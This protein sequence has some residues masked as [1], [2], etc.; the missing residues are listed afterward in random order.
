[1]SIN[2][3]SHLSYTDFP[4][5]FICQWS[6]LV[7]QTFLSTFAKNMPPGGDAID[8]GANVGSHTWTLG[9]IVRRTNNT[10]LSVEPDENNVKILEQ[11][12]KD[13]NWFNMKIIMNP[14]SNVKKNVHF[15]YAENCQLNK[16]TNEDQPN[17]VYMESITLDEI[18]QGYCPKFIKIDVEGQEINAII[19][20]QET[21]LKHR[22]II[23]TEFGASEYSQNDINWYYHFFKSNNYLFLDL[24]GDEFSEIDFVQNHQ[25]YW[26]RFLIPVEYAHIV[27]IFKNNLKVIYSLY[28]LEDNENFKIS[29]D[30]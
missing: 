22:P 8:L 20:G 17:T 21:V 29:F 25:R 12:V 15:L 5:Y 2:Y 3:K 13:T 19:G 30:N 24:F 9:T 14:V 10:V 26:N 28:N 7:V 6:E 23:A 1:M 11:Y 4:D 27:P 18:S 16:I